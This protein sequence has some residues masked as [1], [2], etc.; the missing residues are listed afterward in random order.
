MA[1]TDTMRKTQRYL[2]AKYVLDVRRVE[3]RN[4]GVILWRRAG[5]LHDFSTRPRLFLSPTK[6]PANDG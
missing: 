1:N 4:I 6:K 5:Q 3:P 2:I